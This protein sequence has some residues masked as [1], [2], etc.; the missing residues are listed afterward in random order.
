MKKI[1]KL[2]I[3]DFDGTLAKTPLPE[4]G[5]V[6]FE[7]RTGVAWQHKGWWSK[8]ESLDMDIFDIPLIDE[9]LEAYKK[10]INDPSVM[11]V[12]VTGRMFKLG[13][14]VEK[15]LNYHGLKF[16]KYC[17]NRG[18]DTMNGKLKDFDLLVSELPDLEIV[19]IWEDRVPH[20]E[21]FIEWGDDLFESDKNIKV[22]VNII[23]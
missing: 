12:M 7:K 19:E 5:K 18:G 1:T 22:I 3:F 2:N 21:K 16:D 20:A 17:Y 4:F 23:K 13:P 6:E 15:I 11:N 8:P 14:Q 10:E 9:T